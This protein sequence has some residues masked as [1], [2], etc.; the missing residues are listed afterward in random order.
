ISAF[1]HVLSTR[2]PDKGAVLTQLSLWWFGQLADLVPNHVVSTV[3]PAAV[4]G[5]AT[6]VELLDMV[7]VECVARGYRTGSGWWEYQES[8]TVCGVELPSGLRDGDKLPEPIFTPAIKARV[9]EH[10][11]NVDFATIA[12]IHGEEL[13]TRLRDLTLEIYSRAATI[14]AER[15]IILADTKFEFGLRP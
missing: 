2:I 1:D 5:R 11:Q 3:V 15:G 9:G 12:R 8:R 13:A 14:A 10:D 4:R 7:E 6:V